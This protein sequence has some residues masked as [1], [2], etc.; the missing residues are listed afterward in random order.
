[1]VCGTGDLGLIRDEM[2]SSIINGL[3]ND[4]GG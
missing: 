2:A 3:K 1:M 4:L